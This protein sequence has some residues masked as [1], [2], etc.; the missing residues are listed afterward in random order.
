MSSALDFLLAAETVSLNHVWT[1]S[2]PRL[3]LNPP[4]NISSFYTHESTFGQFP[5]G[6]SATSVT[7]LFSGQHGAP[8]IDA[9]GHIGVN[10]TVFGGTPTSDVQ[11]DQGLL[12]MGID[13]YPEDKYLNRGILLD[14]PYCQGVDRLPENTI[15]TEADVVEC[16]EKE[17]SLTIK[18]GDSVLVRTGYGSLFDTDTAAYMTNY[19]GPSAEVA[20][21]LADKKI[22][23]T[24]ADNLS[25][26]AANTPFPAHVILIPQ[27]GIYIVE[28]MNLEALSEACQEHDTWEFGL[29][30]N[31]PKVKG[32]AA[33]AA[34]SFAVFPGELP[35]AASSVTKSAA[36]ALEG[37]LLGLVLALVLVMF[38]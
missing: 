9:I 17:G 13:E 22:F 38:H 31:P 5:G 10:G 33:M 19:P 28:N 16:L 15:I 25:W 4:Y 2:S 29:V 11:G 12:K 14:M 21:Y 18:E 26:D 27:N 35:V 37:K 3:E 1:T 24:G 32:A 30:M 8:T 34:N 23:L 36:T 7:L 20:T 6:L